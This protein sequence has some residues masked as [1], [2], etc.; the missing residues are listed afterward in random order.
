[1]SDKAEL[2]RI[3][4]DLKKRRSKLFKEKHASPQILIDKTSKLSAEIEQIEIQIK[5]QQ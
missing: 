4:A 3:L 2:E 1:M 5:E